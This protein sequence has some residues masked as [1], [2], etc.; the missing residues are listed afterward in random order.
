M[1]LLPVFAFVLAMLC[2]AARLGRAS[3]GAPW[4]QAALVAAIL[5]GTILIAMTETLSVWNALTPAN[6]AGGW[7]LFAAVGG[8]LLLRGPDLPKVPRT[9]DPL[10][11]AMTAGIG[12]LLLLAGI[13]AGVAPPNTWDSMTYHMPRCVHWILNR[14]VAPYPTHILRQ[15]FREPGAEYAITQLMLLSG[16]DRW[17][18][19][20][21]WSSWIGCQAAVSLVARELGASARA[22]LTAALFVAT[23]PIAILEASSTQN[24]LVVA[25]WLACLAFFAA[26]AWRGEIYTPA[27]GASLGLALITKGT[28]YMFALPLLLWIGASLWPRYGARIWKPALTMATIA[29]M[30]NIGHWSGNVRVFG[31]PIGPEGEL[32]N[33]TID[34]RYWVSNVTRNVALE[35]AFPLSRWNKSMETV[36]RVLHRGLGIGADDA[37]T[38]FP[39]ARFQLLTVAPGESSHWTRNPVGV[40]L[41]EDHAPNPLHMA[42]AL[43]AAL[44]LLASRRTGRGT[45][46]YVAVVVCGFLFFCV[47]LRWQPWHTR[48]HLPLFV[49]TAPA[50]A[51]ATEHWRSLPRWAVCGLLLVCSLPWA[52]YNTTR[53]LAGD[54]SVFRTPRLE[55]YLASRPELL[56]AYRRT[57]EVV[58]QHGWRRLGLVSGGDAGEY[59][60]WKFLG[61]AT[62]L[63][64]VG[65]QNQSAR[66]DRDEG[67]PEATIYLPSPSGWLPFEPKTDPVWTGDSVRIVTGAPQ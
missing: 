26:K 27:A 50:V 58:A 48:L 3:S 22:Q 49:A 43:G 45:R 18:N 20:V 17:V 24:D 34:P 47:A 11:L 38:T 54:N 61:P 7:A 12:V 64:Q 44:L 28:A 46:L 42:L 13:T 29:V 8:V 25:F 51:L 2:A 59:P 39:G 66:L 67:L 9:K 41:Q 53:P 55:Q 33:R 6:V 31:R 36:V 32:L 23:L 65:V 4:R 60:L 52:L 57:A 40:F 16:G 15:L 10:V 37:R 63:D 21:Q 14:S 19:L 1:V 5:C 56:R 30:I 62:M 35:L